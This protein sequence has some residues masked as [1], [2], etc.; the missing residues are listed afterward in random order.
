M[1]LYVGRTRE[2]KR[3]RAGHSTFYLGLWDPVWAEGLQMGV[4]DDFTAAS[5]TH[6]HR[7]ALRAAELIR[8]PL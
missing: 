5:K 6:H 3:A 2:P 4:D 1:E 8:Q 7:R